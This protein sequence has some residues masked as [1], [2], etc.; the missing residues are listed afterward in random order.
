MDSAN[1]NTPLAVDLVLLR[2]DET[3]A[4][5]ST[6]PASKWFATRSDLLKSNPDG[7]RY[8]SMEVVPGQVLKVSAATIGS[9]RFSGAFVF[10]DYLT[11]GE[12]RIRVDQLT[13][14]VV[15][16]LGAKS[17]SAGNLMKR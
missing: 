9:E 14:D 12:H 5:V 13:G 11:P 1:M 3:L 8:V 4:T 17:F 6:M 2:N 16:Q 15:V 10:A 7:L